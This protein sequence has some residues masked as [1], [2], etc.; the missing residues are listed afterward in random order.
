MRFRPKEVTASVL[1]MLSLAGCQKDTDTAQPKP[2]AQAQILT[3]TT[4]SVVPPTKPL[5]YEGPFGLKMG[6]SIEVTKALISGLSKAEPPRARM[7]CYTY[8]C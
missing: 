4:Q 8:P 3:P 7:T 5:T 2:Q 6:L 1:I